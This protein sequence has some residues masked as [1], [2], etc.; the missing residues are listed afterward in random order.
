MSGGPSKRVRVTPFF[1]GYFPL[2]TSCVYLPYALGVDGRPRH[3]PISPDF[4]AETGVDMAQQSTHT[5]NNC[6]LEHSK[7][8]GL[9]CRLTSLASPSGVIPEHHLAGRSFW[10]LHRRKCP[11]D[12]HSYLFDVLT[13]RQLC[14][15][16]D[17]SGLWICLFGFLFGLGGDVT[18]PRP[19][20]LVCVLLWAAPSL[21]ALPCC[22]VCSAP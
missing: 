4:A 12:Q 21:S 20:V 18:L 11:Q 14:N 6:P 2:R 16:L 1:C 5:T 3:W 19:T 10:S 15:L 17:G 9:C 22:S 7:Y 13:N 8:T